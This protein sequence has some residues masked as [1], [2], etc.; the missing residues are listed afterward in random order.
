MGKTRIIAETGAGQH[1]VATAAAAAWFGLKCEIYMGAVDCER[2]KLNIFRMNLLGATVHPV[3]SG[4]RTLKDALDDYA[5]HLDDTFYIVGSA[6]GPY[7]Y[8]QMVRHF[9]SIIGRETKQ[10]VLTKEGRLQ[11]AVIACVGGGSNAI[12]SFAEFIN[13]SGVRLIGAEAAGKGADTPDNAATMTN[14]RVGI[15]DGMRS[16][17]LMD[18]HDHVQPAYSISA[19]LDYPGVGPEH[20]YLKDTHRTEYYAITDDEAVRAFQLL[21]RLEGIIPALESSHAIAQAV[22]MV[23]GMAKDQIVVVTVSG[24]GDKDFNQVADYLGVQVD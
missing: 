6:V 4:T 16:Y 9:Q 11:D 8:P 24:R 19:G 14:G 15:S 20:S 23:P 2:Q 13:S 1:G 21:S 3:Q 18:D 22:K 7:P 10:Q 17:V 5:H 12:G